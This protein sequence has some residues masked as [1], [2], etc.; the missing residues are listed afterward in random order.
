[1]REIGKLEDHAIIF[2]QM[3]VKIKVVI[4]QESGDLKS[5][6]TGSAAL[7]LLLCHCAV[8]L[9]SWILD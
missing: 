7:C 8:F 1:M 3:A 9:R 5:I 2:I 4:L 6:N